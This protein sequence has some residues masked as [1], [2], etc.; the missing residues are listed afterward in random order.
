MSFCQ[1]NLKPLNDNSFFVRVE[2]SG[3]VKHHVVVLYVL[4]ELFELRFK[5]DAPS[6]IVTTSDEV[7]LFSKLLLVTTIVL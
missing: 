2:L 3:P 6:L 4:V 7:L 1:L 5:V